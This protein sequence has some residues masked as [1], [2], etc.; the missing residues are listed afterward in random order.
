MCRRFLTALCSRTGTKTSPG[1]ALSPRRR[2]GRFLGDV[3]GNDDDLVLG[4]VDLLPAE[5]LTPPLGLGLYVKAVDDDRVPAQ[6]HGLTIPAESE[7]RHLDRDR[8]RYP[9]FNT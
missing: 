4:F 2:A 9:Y 6:C 3:C 8:E 5:R 7:G 1:P